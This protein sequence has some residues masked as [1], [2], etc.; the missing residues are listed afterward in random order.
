MPWKGEGLP[1]GTGPPPEEGSDDPPASVEGL[2]PS[3]E[4]RRPASVE[5]RRA[6]VN[7]Q[8]G[9]S[10]SSFMKAV[11]PPS[12]SLFSGLETIKVG[13]ARTEP[14][15]L[16]KLLS[17]ELLPGKVPADAAVEDA[18]REWASSGPLTVTST[19]ASSCFGGEAGL[20]AEA[21]AVAVAHAGA[22]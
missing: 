11:R 12:S 6:P 18:P 5:P 20:F 21:V 9:P 10:S 14:E 2:L 8:S 17:Q 13:S 4:G 22:A 7:S 1:G 16:A 19:P 3:V 15:L